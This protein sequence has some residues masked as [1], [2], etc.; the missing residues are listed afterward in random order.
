MAI[1]SNSL[2]RTMAVF[3]V[4]ACAL[5]LCVVFSTICGRCVCL[6]AGTFA[7]AIRARSSSSGAGCKNTNNGDLAYS[8]RNGETAKHS[9]SLDRISR[10]AP[11][12]KQRKQ[13][14]Q[15]HSDNE[16]CCSRNN[17]KLP[18]SQ[19]R[20]ACAICARRHS[21]LS[22]RRSL[23]TRNADCVATIRQ[24]IPFLCCRSFFGRLPFRLCAP[25]CIHLAGH[26]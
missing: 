5:R 9:R 26:N 12:Q 24:S 22:I 25:S 13:R 11:E 23:S 4:C 20:S 15:Q 18:N 3:R 17:Y 16:V 6:C 21:R 7:S 14:H 8:L 1:A 19:T 10:I 2:T